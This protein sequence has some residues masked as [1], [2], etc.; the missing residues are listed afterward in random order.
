MLAPPRPPLGPMD[1][2]RR[3]IRIPGRI[4]TRQYAMPAAEQFPQ[5][6]SRSRGGGLSYSEHELLRQRKTPHGTV[7]EKDYHTVDKNVQVPASKHVLLSSSPNLPRHSPAYHYAL[8]PPQPPMDHYPNHL[9]ADPVLLPSSSQFQ[10]PAWDF[11]GG[12]DSVLNQSLPTQRYYLQPGSRIPTVLPS[13]LHSYLGPTAS[14]G[15]EHYGPYWPDGTFNPYRPASIR[16][17]RFYGPRLHQQSGYF[18]QALPHPTPSLRKPGRFPSDFITQSQNSMHYQPPAYHL[19]Y[20]QHFQAPHSFNLDPSLGYGGHQSIPK[21]PQQS[22]YEEAAG[23][24]HEFPIDTP[25]L[26]PTAE[27]ETI[28]FRDKTFTWANRIYTELLAV[29]QKNARDSHQSGPANSLAKSNN[30]LTIYPKPPKRSGSH[31]SDSIASTASSSRSQSTAQADS[32]LHDTPSRPQTAIYSPHRRASDHGRFMQQGH[33]QSASPFGPLPFKQDFRRI[34]DSTVFQSSPNQKAASIRH[35]AVS[36]LSTMELLCGQA[37]VPWVDGMLLVGCLAYGLANYDK[38]L[39]WYQLILAQDGEHVEAMSNLAATLFA[40]NRRD[41]ALQYWSAAVTLRPSYFEA[42]EHLIGLLCST[43]RAKEAVDLIEFVESSLKIKP[44]EGPF[45]EPASDA[46]SDAKSHASGATASTLPSVDSAQYDYDS[47]L[48][49]TLL[50]EPSAPGYGSSGYAIAG[51]ENG[52]MLALIHAKGNMLYALGKNSAAAGAFEDAILIA[53][54]QRKAGIK[55]LIRKIL[56]ACLRG[57]V[58]SYEL[59]AK[60]DS[61]HPVLLAPTQAEATARSM[62]P[63]SGQLPGLEFVVQGIALKAA[64]ST[65]SNSLLSLAKI[66]QDAMSSATEVGSLRTTS[67]RDILALYYLS[68]SLQRSPSTANNVGILLAGVQNSVHAPKLSELPNSNI[69]SV[70]GVVPGSGVSL[71]LLYYNYGLNLDPKHAHLYTNLGSLL[72]DIGQL[73]AA[74]KMYENAV[75]CDPTFDIALANLA[76]AVKDQGRVSDAISYYKRAVQANPGFAEA[77][78]GLATALN[79]VC[80]WHGRGGIYA[81]NGQRDRIHVNDSGYLHEATKGYGWM[82]RVVEIVEKQLKEGET[83]GVST[84][85]PTVINDLCRQLTA[86]LNFSATSSDG[87]LDG[88]LREALESWCGKAWEGSRVVRLV[89]R[90]IRRIGWQ[91][92]QDRYKQGKEYPQQRYARPLLPSTLSSPSAPTVLPFHTFTTPLSAKSVRQISQRNALRISVS[93]LRS[94]WLPPTVFPPPPPPRPH[95]VVG[96]VSSDFN[97]HPLA[98]LMQSIFGYHDPTRVHAICYATTPS[99]QSIHRQ[100]IEREVPVFHDASSWSVERL[101]K[102]IVSDHVHILINLN[103]YTRGARNE[104]FAARPAPIQ[105]SFMG[106]AGTLGAEWCDFVLAD[107]ISVPHSTLSPWR[108]N[109]EIVDRLR[110][111]ALCE[112]GDDWVYAENVIF[113][114]DTFF[115]VDHKQSAPDADQGPPRADR[116]QEEKDAA[117]REEQ[118]KRWKLRKE[119][120]P[121][122]SDSA[123]ILGNFNQLYKIDPSTFRMYLRILAAVPNAVLW[124]LRFPDLGE[125]NLLGY[126]QEW[127]GHD[128]WSRVVFTDVAAKGMH[129]TRASVVD[130]FLDTPECNAHTTAADVVWSGTPIVTWGRWGYKMCSRMAGSIVCSAL[131]DTEDGRRAREELVLEG[132]KGEAEYVQRAVKLASGLRYDHAGKGTTEEGE[133]NEEGM[134]KGRLME[135]RRMLWEGRWESRLF[136]TRRWVKD[137]E[138]AYW[139]AWRKWERGEG[140]DIWL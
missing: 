130:V 95:L 35:A 49:D 18:S 111:D 81:E 48:T 119:L 47:D 3:D 96:Y 59:Q 139:L 17:D 13:T 31:F 38:A 5:G 83:W 10:P 126:A 79:S 27:S 61:R 72:K 128:I 54:G 101:V 53:T 76:N 6:F 14:A 89:E 64:V 85:N 60:L 19:N 105:M 56:R 46:D 92:Y 77:V 55:G 28:A 74:I 51:S 87:T 37:S 122:L 135:I 98:H 117:W 2:S 82:N 69:C 134:G 71:A 114:K 42:V 108:R 116:T 129:I 40:L 124:L 136:D 127:A 93:T 25:G 33:N 26:T 73:G 16:D 75:S 66:Y 15:Q 41:E 12:L 34:S 131:P 57:V 137:L 63:A 104:V 21:L 23:Y 65:T 8:P 1:P 7:Y 138:R 70:P 121:T 94:A 20:H 9:G 113:A 62:F 78:C 133:V 24:L 32:I 22:P 118:R 88:V 36:A 132:V 44:D 52:R 43:R 4:S 58:D 80:S 97:N 30:K 110:P 125:Q 84:L 29:I 11:P 103:G 67:T 90:A 115:C 39:K 107:E 102:Q 123:V 140:G 45:G 68:L 100:Q 106:F 91:W 120:F 86:H 50:R 109:V 99:D 112:D